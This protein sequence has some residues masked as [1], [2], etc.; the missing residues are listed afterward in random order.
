MISV[1]LVSALLVFGQVFENSDFTVILLL[2]T[3]YATSTITFCFFVSTFFDSANT[4]AAAGGLLYFL[5][6]VP[7]YFAEQLSASDRTAACLLGP[8][9]LGFGIEVLAR[10]E[11]AG[12]GLQWSNLSSPADELDPFTMSTV[13]G[14]LFVGTQADPF[15]R[16]L[17]I[18]SHLTIA[19]TVLY[20]I[21]AWYIEKIHPGQYGI[22][23]PLLFPLYPSFWFG[24]SRHRGPTT[25]ATSGYEKSASADHEAP[26]EGLRPG[27]EIRNL[28]KVFHVHG[29]DKVAVDDLSLSLYEDQV[30]V[31]L[32]HNGAG[33][34]TT[35]SV[36]VGLYAPTSGSVTIGGHDVT[37]ERSAARQS[38]GLCPQF[39][40]LFATLTVEENLQ[41]FGRLKGLSGEELHSQ[42]DSYIKDMDLE[43]KRRSASKTLSGGQKRALSVGIA[44]IGDSEVVILDEPTSGMDPQKRR[45]TWDVI[46]NYKKGRTILLTTHFLDEADL[47]GDRIAILSE[48]RLSCSGR[49][50]F[51]KTRFGVGYHLTMVKGAVCDTEAVLTH[52]SESVQGIILEDDLG[53]EITCLIPKVPLNDLGKLVGGLEENQNALGIDSF[54]VQVTTLEEVRCQCRCTSGVFLISRS[55]TGLLEHRQRK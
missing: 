4:A 55:L 38:L 18:V 23:M 16:F 6:Y 32:G 33:K 41:F 17:L 53:A 47:L 36:M 42:V 2:L 40:I 39:D 10:H 5:A 1:V 12:R 14:M 24:P 43:P 34:T 49:S 51:L 9:C 52:L 22:P 25:V 19:D 26:P 37:T 30:T 11:V 45:H 44:F 31:L 13:I 35:M 8:S 54:G 7:S 21:L 3:L 15:M 27:V 29:Q 20:F 48:G 28:R 50:D 46:I